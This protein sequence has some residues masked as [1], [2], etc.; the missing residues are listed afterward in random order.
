MRDEARH[1]EQPT[2]AVRQLET[3][4][5]LA[6]VHPGPEAF[7]IGPEVHDAQ[8]LAVAVEPELPQDGE[9]EVARPARDRHERRGAADDRAGRVALEAGVVVFVLLGEQ[10]RAIEEDA[11][12]GVGALEHPPGRVACG[13]HVAT[14]HEAHVV[15][16]GEARGATRPEQQP[17]E[18]LGPPPAHREPVHRPVELSVHLG[19]IGVLRR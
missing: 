14:I 5:Q 18:R 7:G 3:P 2:P 19:C 4:P 17:R 6:G 10:V 13:L 12:G 16:A 1:R 15:L 9:R 11:I 8:A